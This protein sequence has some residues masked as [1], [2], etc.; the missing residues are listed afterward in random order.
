MLL[1]C[2]SQ[3]CCKFLTLL[4][5]LVVVLHF[6][7]VFVGSACWKCVKNRFYEL[8]WQTCFMH[9]IKLRV[10]KVSTIQIV[11]FNVKNFL[12]L[13]SIVHYTKL[14]PVHWLRWNL[15]CSGQTK[16]YMH[17]SSSQSPIHQASQMF[18]NTVEWIELVIYTALRNDNYTIVTF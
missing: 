14:C 3:Q 12:I 7:S 1:F 2:I 16:V 4:H 15:A 10:F 8:S 13:T 6:P 18:V 11:I 9:H 5:T 17:N